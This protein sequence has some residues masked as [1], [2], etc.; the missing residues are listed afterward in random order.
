MIGGAT[1]KT[2]NA[3]ARQWFIATVEKDELLGVASSDKRLE[4]VG[5]ALPNGAGASLVGFANQTHRGRVAPGD[6]VN[7]E[8]RSFLHARA[9]L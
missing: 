2:I 4:R 3:E 6:G 9:V 5:G 1:D 7:R 8:V